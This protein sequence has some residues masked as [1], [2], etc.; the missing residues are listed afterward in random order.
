MT[1]MALAKPRP[2]ARVKAAR[3]RRKA[4]ARAVC[5]AVVWQRAGSRCEWCGTRVYQQADA[6]NALLMG[7]VH[8][9]G[10]RSLG[11]DPTDLEQCVLVCVPCHDAAHGRTR[12][13]SSTSGGRDG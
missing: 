4:T 8:E 1:G 2:R 11:A 13:L 3:N 10:R 7:H 5:V 12:P 6:P 9:L